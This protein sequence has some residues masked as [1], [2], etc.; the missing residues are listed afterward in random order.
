MKYIIILISY[1]GMLSLVTNCGGGASG[2]SSALHDSPG[3]D[4]GFVHYFLATPQEVAPGADVTLSWNLPSATD[5]ELLQIAGNL[6]AKGSQIVRPTQSTT[7]T[8]R[9]KSH[10]G[11]LITRQ[12]QV[13]V[14]TQ[15]VPNAI[16]Y[17]WA[18]HLTINAG[19]ASILNW[20]ANRCARVILEAIGQPQFTQTLPCVGS[21]EVRPTFSG[22]W[23]LRAFDQDNR[24]VGTSSLVI[25]VNPVPQPSPVI[26]AFWTNYLNLDAGSTA[27]I[28]WTVRNA[29][30][31]YLS[32]AP[33]VPQAASG[34]ITVRPLQTTT[35]FLRALGVSG[36]V[37]S[38]QFTITVNTRL[39]EIRLFAADQPFL[40]PGQTTTLRWDVGFCSKVELIGDI[41]VTVGC[42]GSWTVAPSQ[43]TNYNLIASG[44]NGEI[45]NQIITVTAVQPQA[46]PTVEYFYADDSTVNLGQSTTLR[47]KVQNCGRVSIAGVNSAVLPCE[48]SAVV[49]PNGTQHYPL[50]AYSPDGQKQAVVD[51]AIG[52]L[53]PPPPAIEYFYAS[54]TA[55]AW[56]E[57]T[58]LYWKVSQAAKVELISAT[59]EQVALQ[60]AKEFQLVSTT[61]FRLRVTGL[62]GEVIEAPLT[63]NVAPPTEQQLLDKLLKEMQKGG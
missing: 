52:V 29:S 57:S 54:R 20:K 41:R 61:S 48:G 44:F 38:Q 36:E 13:D 46:L 15:P 1:L 59:S 62:N 9:A 53:L 37:V 31:V 58:T 56:E 6:P 18:S 7:Y 27:N 35:Y 30:A 43:T 23:T 12:V 10:T 8:I 50:T 45:V 24:P 16:E 11:R 47:W 51:L 14:R 17:F 3:E 26:E 33:E 22:L 42:S 2:P 19:E 63:I 34:S 28:Y 49:R 5:I 60:S 21:V 55:I 25:Q 40:Q 4:T 32:T 39:P